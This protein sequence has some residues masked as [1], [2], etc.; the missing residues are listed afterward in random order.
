V[1]DDTFLSMWVL[2]MLEL[3]KS[4]CALKKKDVLRLDFISKIN[5]KI[6]AFGIIM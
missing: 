1:G 5:N 3:F 2:V 4:G 6:T